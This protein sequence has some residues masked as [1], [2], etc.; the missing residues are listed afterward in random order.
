MVRDTGPGAGASSAAERDRQAS[1]APGKPRAPLPET[2]RFPCQLSLPLPWPSPPPLG[3]SCSTVPSEPRKRSQCTRRRHSL[4]LR[5][6][7]T[8]RAGA[9][10]NLLGSKTPFVP[11]RGSGHPRGGRGGT[12]LPRAAGSS[13]APKPQSRAAGGRSRGAA[14]RLRHDGE[15]GAL[16]AQLLSL[17]DGG[18]CSAFIFSP[19]K[20]KRETRTNWIDERCSPWEGRG[21]RRSHEPA[22]TA[23]LPCFSSSCLKQGLGRTEECLAEF[24]VPVKSQHFINM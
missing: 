14:H 20:S 12:F 1:A 24:P 5:S 10:R 13:P 15:R 19:V 2:S 23:P 21:E 16:P 8:R 3:L 18:S 17:A 4:H 6:H 11:P 22:N 9:G 7:P